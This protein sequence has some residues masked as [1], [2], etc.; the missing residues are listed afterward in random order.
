MQL[1]GVAL[2]WNRLNPRLEKVLGHA[3]N[4]L[5]NAQVDIIQFNDSILSRQRHNER[6]A[7]IADRAQEAAR[8]RLGLVALR[9]A[10]AELLILSAEEGLSHPAW[11]S[12]PLIGRWL[13]RFMREH[14][15]H[16]RTT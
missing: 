9:P 3:R 5:Q 6:T 11:H 14:E 1:G 4:G 10:K 8:M 2:A 12:V 7:R 13:S 15:L 16:T